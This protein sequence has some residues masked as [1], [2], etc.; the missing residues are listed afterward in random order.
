MMKGY[1]ILGLFLLLKFEGSMPETTAVNETTMEESGLLNISTSMP[2][3]HEVPITSKIS[4]HSIAGKV[5]E[6]SSPLRTQFANQNLVHKAQELAITTEEPASTSQEPTSTSQ[7]PT[8]TSMVDKSSP[9]P[10]KEELQNSSSSSISSILETTQMTTSMSSNLNKI[11]FTTQSIIISTTQSGQNTI[12]V[13]GT[14]ENDFTTSATTSDNDSQMSKRPLGQTTSN[15]TETKYVDDDPEETTTVSNENT[16]SG[17]TNPNNEPPVRKPGSLWVLVLVLFIILCM[18]LFIMIVL[19]VRRKK[20]SGSQTFNK[21]SRKGDKKDVWAGQV[22]E[23]VEGKQA[24]EAKGAENGV[25]VPVSEAGKEEKLT[26]FVSGEKKSDSVIEMDEL[27]KEKIPEVTQEKDVKEE[28]MVAKG[29]QTPLLEQP[30]VTPNGEVDGKD[31]QF[32]LPPME[33]ELIGN[34]DKT[35]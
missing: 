11:N 4:K 12:V 33:Q 25:T 26:T 6:T 22:P 8:N 13:N 23:L 10:V 31:E 28:D 27:A 5:S 35:I 16:G 21:R 15:N 18:I 17:N 32:P 1:W 14:E 34:T 7:E 3:D 9:S 29:E 2:P 24:G 19:L 20:R 30:E